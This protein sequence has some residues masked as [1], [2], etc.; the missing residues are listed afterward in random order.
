M[1]NKLENVSKQRLFETILSLQ[2]VDEC[3]CFFNDICTIN[4]IQSIVQRLDVAILLEKGKTYLE[5]GKYTGASTATISRVNRCLNHGSNG[6]RLAINR[7][8][9]KVKEGEI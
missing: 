3:D 1:N 4:E 8:K 7:N 6:Y 5:V 2:N 9:D